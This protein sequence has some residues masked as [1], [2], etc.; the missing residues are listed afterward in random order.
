M[1]LSLFAIVLDGPDWIEWKNVDRTMKF[2]ENKDNYTCSS[3]DKTCG[4][5]QG[6]AGSQNIMISIIANCDDVV[7]LGAI[8]G[9]IVGGA[10][11]GFSLCLATLLVMVNSVS[12]KNPWKAFTSYTASYENKAAVSS[13]TDVM[14]LYREQPTRHPT[15]VSSSTSS[16]QRHNKEYMPAWSLYGSTVD[17]VNNPEPYA[18]QS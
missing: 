14:E 4:C 5:Q 7:Y 12:W 18:N 6:G 1:A 17:D 16:L 8:Y 3:N 9:V 11:I 2:W 13:L 15:L 10:V